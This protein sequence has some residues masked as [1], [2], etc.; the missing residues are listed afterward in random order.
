MLDLI[1]VCFDWNDRPLLYRN[2]EI[3]VEKLPTN[4]PNCE[5]FGG[6]IN[7]QL[8]R[9]PSSVNRLLWRTW[10]FTLLGDAA[11]VVHRKSGG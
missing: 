2:H 11:A 4:R 9:V 10:Q 3:E 5:W 8:H 6:N 1:S 7:G